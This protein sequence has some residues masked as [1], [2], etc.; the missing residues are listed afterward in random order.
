MLTLFRLRSVI[1]HM[2]QK[3]THQIKHRLWLCAQ[4][5]SYHWCHW[6]QCRKHSSNLIDWKH[7]DC[8]LHMS[9]IL[10]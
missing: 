2:K 5:A 8:Y 10:H 4:W 7:S 3:S 1:L 6:R 9:W